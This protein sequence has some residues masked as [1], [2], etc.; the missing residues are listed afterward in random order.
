M[1]YS[2]LAHLNKG[3]VSIIWGLNPLFIAFIDRALYKQPLTLKH[4]LGL[5]ALIF[6]AVAI[7]L[8]TKV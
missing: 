5:T 8:S 1:Y 4:Y 3:V 7:I 2:Q 6:C